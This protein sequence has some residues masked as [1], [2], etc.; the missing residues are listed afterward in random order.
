MV[1][2]N[3]VHRLID[4]ADEEEYEGVEKSEM[5]QKSEN[6]PPPLSEPRLMRHYPTF[7]QD[8]EQGEIMLE[9]LKVRKVCTMKQP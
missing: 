7:Y 2:Q 9:P 4:E 1:F 6:P 8:E 5:S 3:V